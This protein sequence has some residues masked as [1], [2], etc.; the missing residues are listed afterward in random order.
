MPDAPRIDADLV[1]HVARLARLRLT[2]E[3]VEAMAPQLA[4]IFA[5]V[6]QVGALETGVHDPATQ[7]PIA[8]EALRADEPGPTLRVQD[9]LA[10]APAHDGAFLVVP[11]F[12]EE[13]DPEA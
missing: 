7:P 5:H 8:V 4:R 9:L 3:E 6:E 12:F 1:R 13:E 10:V 11:R 2:D